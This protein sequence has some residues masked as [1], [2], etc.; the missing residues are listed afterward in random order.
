M[1]SPR[2]RQR[3]GGLILAGATAGASTAALVKSNG[4]AMTGASIGP[5]CPGLV[6]VSQPQHGKELAS[7]VLM[8]AR[9]QDDKTVT[10][11]DT[12]QVRRAKP[13]YGFDTPGPCL[14]PGGVIGR[15]VSPIGEVLA[16]GHLRQLDAG[17]AQSSQKAKRRPHEQLE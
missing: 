1:A 13:R 7:S 11:Q 16:E 5:P 10:R 6:A 17:I 3:T 12:T 4:V 8:I 15:P 9:R 2:Q 14:E